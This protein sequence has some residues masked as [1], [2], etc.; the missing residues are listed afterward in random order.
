MRTDDYAA[1]GLLAVLLMISGCS[2]DGDS[3]S[4]STDATTVTP[5]PIAVADEPATDK[6]QPEEETEKQQHMT[7]SS[8][9]DLT[10]EETY[11]IIDKGTE[12]PGTGELL[13]N[14]E[15]GTYICRRCN[16][17]LYKSADKFESHCGWPS[18]DDEIKGAVRREADADGY[19]VEILCQNCDG[20]LG[21]V[22]KGEKMTAKDTRH[23]VNSV[24]MSFVKEGDEL[25]A[26]I[27]LED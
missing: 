6:R 13:N 16:A 25:P 18:F 2:S 11:I 17:A 19:R 9:N 4:S 3:V 15:P 12:A 22:F 21:H 7:A 8:Y 20:H 23:C 26:M 24:S 1:T 14:K 27:K 5:A 10:P